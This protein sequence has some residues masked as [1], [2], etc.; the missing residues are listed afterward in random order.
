MPNY[1]QNEEFIKLILVY[2]QTKNKILYN[3]IGK[4]FLAIA[5]N[6][7]RLPIF[8]NYSYDRQ[9]EMISDAVFYMTKNLEDYDPLFASDDA[10]EGNPFSYFTTVAR[11]AFF[12]KIAE[13]K[14]RDAMFKPI[15]YIDNIESS[16]FRKSKI[17]KDTVDIDFD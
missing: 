1:I 12:Q 8:I 17:F 7:L 6:V 16:A 13:Y 9:C 14:K 15:D 10:N 5:K 11:R 4:R 2:R 3:E